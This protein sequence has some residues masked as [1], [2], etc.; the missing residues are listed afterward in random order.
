MG[1]ISM[2]QQINDRGN[3]RLARLAKIYS[4]IW[5]W[6]KRYDSEVVLRKEKAIDPNSKLFIVGES[7][8]KDQVRLT[9]VNWFNENGT[10]GAAGSNLEQILECIGYTIKPPRRVKFGNVGVEP[11]T[12]GRHTVYT[13]DICPCHPHNG[14]DLREETKDA[15]DRKFLRREIEIVRPNIILL[16]GSKSFKAF[17][18]HVLGKDIPMSISH[19]F[20]NLAPDTVGGLEKYMDAIIVPFYHPSPANGYFT[21]W[22]KENS[23]LSQTPQI[24]ALQRIVTSS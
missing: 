12:D 24:K 17:F 22:Q 10:I 7:N 19:Y 9:G 4:E 5:H 16:L 8:A 1:S 13:T 23:P 20:A 11:C 3:D 14:A 2:D 6:C 21:S 15:L 18:K